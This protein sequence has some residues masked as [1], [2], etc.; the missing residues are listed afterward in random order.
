MTLKPTRVSACPVQLAPSPAAPEIRT[1]ARVLTPVSRLTS[2]L[3]GHLTVVC[4]TIIGV[5]AC[6]GGLGQ[7]ASQFPSRDALEPFEDGTVKPVSPH[8]TKEV[9]SWSLALE[10]GSDEANL[11]TA[12]L[13][14]NELSGSGATMSSSLNCAARELARFYAKHQALPDRHFRSYVAMRCGNTAVSL[15]VG[16]IVQELG[17]QSTDDL[18]EADVAMVQRN[19]EAIA[20]SAR[21]VLSG[22]SSAVG[23]GYARAE[24]FGAVM[25][26]GTAERAELVGFE[27]VVEGESVSLS[28]RFLSEIDRAVAVI[29]SG[30]HGVELCE[31][32]RSVAYPD[33]RVTCPMRTEDEQAVLE[34]LTSDKGRV[35]MTVVVSALVRRSESAALEYVAPAAGSAASA[36][37]DDEF[38]AALLESINDVRLSAGLGQLKLETEQSATNRRLVGSYFRELFAGDEENVETM[39]LGALAGWNVSGSIKDG[40]ILSGFATQTDNPARLLGEMLSSP[41]GRWILLEPAATRIAVGARVFDQPALAA[42]MTTYEFFD[43]AD[44]RADENA[45]FEQLVKVRKQRGLPA[46]VRFSAP[47]LGNALDQV[48][49]QRASTEQALNVAMSS[50]AERMQTGV[51]GLMME[52]N[53]I[54]HIDFSEEFLRDGPLS[55]G[56]AVTHYK[57]PGA[58]W[59]QYAILMV[60]AGQ[61]PHSGEVATLPTKQSGGLS[62]EQAQTPSRVQVW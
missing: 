30:P 33:F 17:G 55:V 48:R 9:K 35:L 45:I 25:L 37:S 21:Q 36:S 6:G 28:G 38:T 54:T 32:D 58:A 41:S 47:E 2:T 14:Q 34:I 19:E 12:R 57:P 11:L 7:P 15:Q 44:H 31:A 5:A 13:L 52:T 3:T 23:V 53:Q 27:P 61:E 29:N 39:A 51:A 18:G 43:D 16:G 49:S 22:R 26:V 10:D 20:D 40:G 62:A 42:L 24:G 4:L 56:V 8:Q 46:P 50:V 60:R 1:P 59:A